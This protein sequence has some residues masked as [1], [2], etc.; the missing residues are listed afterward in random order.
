MGGKDKDPVWCPII[1]EPVLRGLGGL[2]LGQRNGMLRDIAIRNEIKKRMWIGNDQCYGGWNQR[3][4][5]K[6]F[7][8]TKHF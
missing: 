5:T 6:E 2:G 8:K 7:V 4:E 3:L 1:Q